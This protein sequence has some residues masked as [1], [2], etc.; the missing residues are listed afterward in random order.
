MVTNSVDHVATV[1]TF[2]DLC[3]LM[4]IRISST[5][6]TSAKVTPVAFST[7]TLAWL[8]PM[9]MSPNTLPEPS[10]PGGSNHRARCNLLAG[11]RLGYEI[12]GPMRNC[13]FAMTTRARAEVALRHSACSAC[14][15]TFSAMGAHGA[16]A[17]MVT[18]VLLLVLALRVRSWAKSAELGGHVP[19]RGS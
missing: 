3:F 13:N 1:S 18:G 5:P 12:S 11:S 6:A 7:S 14:S 2:D 15:R 16:Q 10:S 19:V 8:L 4:R 9:D 17:A